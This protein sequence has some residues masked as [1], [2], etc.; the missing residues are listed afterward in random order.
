MGQPLGRGERKAFAEAKDRVYEL[1]NGYEDDSLLRGV[2]GY[3]DGVMGAEQANRLAA[4]M[5]DLTQ[6]ILE[7]GRDLQFAPRWGMSLSPKSMD[8]I[9]HKLKASPFAL[10][11][12][13]G[14]GSLLAALQAAKRE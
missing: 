13:A 7:E 1:L 8:Y 3:S 5:P 12:A 4:S 2:G 6:D 11:A 14:G 10:A 9:I